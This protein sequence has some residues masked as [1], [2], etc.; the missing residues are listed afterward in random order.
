MK[1]CNSIYVDK[2]EY[3]YNLV[4][5]NG[6]YYFLSRPHGFG[7]SRMMSTLEAIFKGR[8]DL[9]KG[10]YIDTTDYAWKE[11]PVIHIDFS[12]CR[13]KTPDDIERWIENKLRSIMAFYKIEEEADYTYDEV[14]KYGIQDLSEVGEVVVLIENHDAPILY[15][16]NNEHLDEIR[17][18]FF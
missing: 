8:R 7:M 6:F 18:T 9:F 15:N 1:R 16:L 17:Y 14:L 4:K 3:L 2:T 13:E 10:L 11:Y 12:E 5:E